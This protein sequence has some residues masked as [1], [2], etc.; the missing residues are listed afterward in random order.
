[1]TTLITAAKETTRHVVC[2]GKQ[3]E[4]ISLECSCSK[5]GKGVL[6]ELFHTFINP[7]IIYVF[8]ICSKDFCLNF[9]SA[10]LLTLCMHYRS[11]GME[12]WDS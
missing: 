6:P 1:M 4:Q 7:T 11:F 3:S 10:L 8:I 2:K 12:Y 5:V 9:S